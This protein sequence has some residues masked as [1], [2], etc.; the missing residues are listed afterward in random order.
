MDS[1]KHI[2]VVS[3]LVRNNEGKILLIRHPRRGWEVPQG[4]VEEGED[5]LAAARREVREETGTE[6]EIGP[7]AAVWSKIS[8]PPAVIFG[9]CA[10][11][12]SGELTTSDES[13]EVAWQYPDEA[14]SLVSHPVSRDRLAA[15]LAF[16]GDTLYGTY[17]TNP[18]RVLTRAS[19]GNSIISRST[20][21]PPR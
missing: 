9:F 4:R 18:Y 14:L 20:T 8:P 2:I 6:V 1:P 7:L 17:D 3:C 13:L 12:Q 11:Y 21:F 10:R 15:L 5:L 16:D 19:L